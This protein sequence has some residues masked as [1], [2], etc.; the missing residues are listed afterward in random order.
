MLYIKVF[1]WQIYQK[2]IFF[3]VFW[4]FWASQP[5]SLVSYKFS[6]KKKF[7]PLFDN[8]FMYF[9]HFW[10]TSS[11]GP[12]HKKF[13]KRIYEFFKISLCFQNRQFSAKNRKVT[14]KLYSFKNTFALYFFFKITH[15]RVFFFTNLMVPFL[16]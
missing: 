11:Q 15:L 13:K 5:N 9:M 6:N 2:I 12:F 3:V 8:F 14:V 1:F 7:K 16:F 4:G 10:T